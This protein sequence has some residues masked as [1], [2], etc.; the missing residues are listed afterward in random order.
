MTPLS[1]DAFLHEFEKLCG[2]LGIETAVGDDQRVYC[3]DL[4]VAVERAT[5]AVH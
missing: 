1:V 3:V 4:K 2:K 5:A